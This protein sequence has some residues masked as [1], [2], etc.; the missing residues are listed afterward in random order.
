MEHADWADERMPELFPGIRLDR[1]PK[2][3]SAAEATGLLK[4]LVRSAKGLA[5]DANVL[6]GHNRYPRA[7][8]LAVLSFEEIGKLEPVARLVGV[9]DQR[10]IARRWRALFDHSAKS[11]RIAGV[12]PYITDPDQIRLWNDARR[13]FGRNLNEL[14]QAALY[15]NC[16]GDGNWMSPEDVFGV[17]GRIDRTNVRILVKLARAMAS[18][19]RDWLNTSP[20]PIGI[21]CRDQDLE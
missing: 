4:L 15:V 13:K 3:F 2:S 10:E 19:T 20:D 5:D 1:N 11:A 21:L 12:P 16:F 14:K 18:A 17:R 6:L 9:T 7:A 8:A